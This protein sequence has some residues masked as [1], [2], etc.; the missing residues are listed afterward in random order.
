MGGVHAGV[1]PMARLDGKIVVVADMDDVAVCTMVL[2]PTVAVSEI[3][4]RDIIGCAHPTIPL[5]TLVIRT[6]R[7]DPPD[8]TT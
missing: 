5:C 4:A 1:S 8:T 6:D 7:F 3:V 2:V